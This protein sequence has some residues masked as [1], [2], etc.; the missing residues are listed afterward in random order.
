[1][2]QVSY[3]EL[4]EAGT[5]FGHRISRWNPSMRPYIFGKRNGIHILDVRETLKGLIRASHAALKM[6]ASGGDIIFVGTKRQSRVLVEQHAKRCGM[7]YVVD[8][9]LGGTLTNFETIRRRIKRLEE[10]EAS[11]LD[12]TIRQHSK[13]IISSLTREKR[14]MV[15]NLQGLRAMAALP[16]GIIVIDPKRED[17]CVKEAQRLGVVTI[18]LLD[19]DCNPDE[20]DFPIPGNDDGIKSIEIFLRVMADAALEGRRLSG[21]EAA[22]GAEAVAMEAAA[23]ARMEN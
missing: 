20:V 2:I 13:K 6:S 5:H 16:A 1:M 7:P 8:R 10:I 19:T 18:A 21:R 4:L 23:A 17:N 11:E 12:G 3:R 9:W 14:K 22:L 15:R